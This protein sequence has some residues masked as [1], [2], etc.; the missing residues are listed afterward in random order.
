MT[1]TLTTTCICF[2][3]F[4][5]CGTTVVLW[6]SCAL[7]F[8]SSLLSAFTPSHQSVPSSHRLRFEQLVVLCGAQEVTFCS[9]NCRVAMATGSH[10]ISR[11]DTE[12]HGDSGS[13]QCWTRRDYWQYP[14]CG[15]EHKPGSWC[16]YTYTFFILTL[17]FHICDVLTPEVEAVNSKGWSGSPRAKQPRRRRW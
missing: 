16:S 8:V 12:H 1:C 11:S 2:F 6:C 4:L 15:V 3:D 10:D 17:H 14:N 7:S 5:F 9:F 13:Q